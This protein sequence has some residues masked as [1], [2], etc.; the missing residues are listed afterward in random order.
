M[1]NSFLSFCFQ[2]AVYSWV[3]RQSSILHSDFGKL[4]RVWV[5]LLAYD[6]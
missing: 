1:Q 5:R 6:S 2:L 3:G 4:M